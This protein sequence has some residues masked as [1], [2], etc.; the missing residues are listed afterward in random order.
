[1]AK[2]PTTRSNDLASHLFGKL[3]RIRASTW[4]SADQWVIW[5]RSP[6]TGLPSFQPVTAEEAYRLMIRRAPYKHFDLDAIASR[7]KNMG[8]HI[9]QRCWENP[10]YSC[11]IGVTRLT[12][13]DSFVASSRAVLDLTFYI[14]AGSTGGFTALAWKRGDKRRCFDV[15]FVVCDVCRVGCVRR[16]FTALYEE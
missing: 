10:I 8:H 12:R 11:T 4:S 13:R 16:G 7:N 14:L 3:D 9:T 2:P 15:Y 6:E 1:V 5:T